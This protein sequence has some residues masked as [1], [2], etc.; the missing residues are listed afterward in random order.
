MALPRVRQQPTQLESSTRIKRG[1]GTTDL[2]SRDDDQD[3]SPRPRVE[4]KIPRGMPVLPGGRRMPPLPVVIRESL[5]PLRRSLAPLLQHV[6]TRSAE[7]VSEVTPIG[8]VQR[9]RRRPVV[10]LTL[11]VVLVGAAVAWRLLSGS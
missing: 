11:L 5:K 8:G 7:R 1:E 10:A 4:M 9:P 3:E 2:D 6:T